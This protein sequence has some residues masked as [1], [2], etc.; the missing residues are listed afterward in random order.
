[1][2]NY[3]LKGNNNVIFKICA[4]E[5]ITDCLLLFSLILLLL[6]LH[7]QWVIINSKTKYIK[8]WMMD[9]RW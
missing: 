7:K 4:I 3:I 9:N 2:E 8:Y 6:L 5:I 1:M